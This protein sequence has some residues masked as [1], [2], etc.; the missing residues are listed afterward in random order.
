MHSTESKIKNN[1]QFA[2]NHILLFVKQDILSK[3]LK[4]YENIIKMYLINSEKLR[5]IFSGLLVNGLSF[6]FYLIFIQL[7]FMPKEA[8]TILYWLTVL[9]NFFINKKFVFNN[10]NNIYSTFIKYF[11]VYIMGYFISLLFMTI[12][13]D[14]FMYDHISSMIA[15]SVIMPI[16]FYLMQKYLVF[17]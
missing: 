2:E 3:M 16:Y 17:R 11:S 14:F 9:V 7:G 1:F 4:I 13:M 12:A 15:A 5:Y 6:I 8:L 10:K